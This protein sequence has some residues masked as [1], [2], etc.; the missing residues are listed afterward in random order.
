M[1]GTTAMDYDYTGQRVKKFGPL[2]LVLYPFA[3]Y[4]IGPDGTKTKFFRVGAEMLAAKQSPVSNPEK[5]LFYHNDHLGGVNVITDINGLKVQLN[6]YDPWGKVSSTEGNV[7]PEKRFTGQILDPE[8]GLYYYGAR[9]YDPELARF[10]SPDPIVPSPGDPQT[11]N[12]YSYVR[13]NPVRYIDPSGMSFWSA[14]AN[15]FKGFFRSVPALVTGIV[16]GIVA[17][18]I[19][20]GMAAAVNTAINGGNF[21]KAIGYGAL[22]GGIAG[23][24]GG[25]IYEGFGGVSNGVFDLTN[26]VAAVKTGAVVGAVFGGISTA[27]HGGNFFRNVAMGALGGAVSSAAAFGIMKGGTEAYAAAK[28]SWNSLPGTTAEAQKSAA[29]LQLVNNYTKQQLQPGDTASDLCTQVCGEEK[30][31][32]AQNQQGAAQGAGGKNPTWANNFFRAI[33]AM[34]A[35]GVLETAEA[36]IVVGLHATTLGPVGIAVGIPVAI[37]GVGIGVG[38]LILGANAIDVQGTVGLPDLKFPKDSR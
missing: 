38:G 10:I 1:G 21:G 35:A 27:I 4:E 9:Y 7:D 18:P 24:I 23:V 16:V 12:R 37:L 31:L 32:N 20:G 30:P 19:F 28:E 14:I 3:G 25:P 22:F 6:E 17:G 15:F 13:N 29:G 8:S 2:G 5:K 33:A 34:A 11:L 26:F 36:L